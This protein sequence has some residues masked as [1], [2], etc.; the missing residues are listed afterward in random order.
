MSDTSTRSLESALVEI[1]GWAGGADRLSLVEIRSIASV[2][3]QHVILPRRLTDAQLGEMYADTAI[4]LWT[5]R[6]ALSRYCANS[7]W[8][9]RCAYEDQPTSETP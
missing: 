6:K 7:P 1:I 4:P 9:G 8:E 3:A 2:L 5:F